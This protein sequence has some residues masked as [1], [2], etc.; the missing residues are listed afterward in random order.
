MVVALVA[1]FL[2]GGCAAEFGSAGYYRKE[3]VTEEQRRADF[4][5]CLKARKMTGGK[6][7]GIL[8]FAPAAGHISKAQDDE[9]MT[10]KGYDATNFAEP[11][12][13]PVKPER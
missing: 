10:Q 6:V 12:T 2:L 13:G 3:G 4:Q 5:E 8:F 7:L 9:C 11:V 1:A